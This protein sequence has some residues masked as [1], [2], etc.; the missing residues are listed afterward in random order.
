MSATLLRAEIILLGTYLFFIL[1]GCI[2]VYF[3][4][5]NILSFLKGLGLLLFLG[6][7]PALGLY[8][9]VNKYYSKPEPI[10]ICDTCIGGKNQ[11]IYQDFTHLCDAS[12]KNST[13]FT[14]FMPLNG[15]LS[16]TDTCIICWETFLDHNTRAEQSYFDAVFAMNESMNY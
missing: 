11:K 12:N 7:F 9:N 15:E 3:E 10:I 5:K 6:S 13:A 16:Q 4:E 2:L 14:S 8:I 1:L